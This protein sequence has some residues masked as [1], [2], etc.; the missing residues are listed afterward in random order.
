MTADHHRQ[1]L[2]PGDIFVGPYAGSSKSSPLAG[3]ML[4]TFST[5][6]SLRRL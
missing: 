2:P 5:S 4:S 3:S 6:L 1:D